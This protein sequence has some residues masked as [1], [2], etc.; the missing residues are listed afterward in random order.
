MVIASHVII[1]MYGFW[2]PNDERGSWSDFVGSWE[3]LRF[4]K[5]TTVT[6]RHSVA[7][8]PFDRAR[9]AAALAELKYPPVKL[10]GVQARAVARGFAAYA[11]KADLTI[12]AC[13]ILPQ[14][15]HVV[16]ARH[17]LKVESLVTQLKGDATERLVAE[18]VHPLAQYRTASGRTPKVF[19]RGEWKV[20]LNQ[21]RDIA[22]AIGY[23]ERNPIREGL[24][25]QRWDFVTSPSV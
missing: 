15:I 2:L 25:P 6:V 10:N 11:E 20:F 14:H 1:G 17:R 13:A 19:G 12:L 8:R 22:R 18:G 5:A 3:L 16:L 9:R 21:P 7:R 4:G 23:V 24:R